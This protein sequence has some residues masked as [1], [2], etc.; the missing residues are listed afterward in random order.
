M[1]IL[2]RY[3]A[4]GRKEHVTWLKYGL[5][6]TYSRAILSFDQT[7]IICLDRYIFHLESVAGPDA[8]LPKYI[9]S[10]RVHLRVQAD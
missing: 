4:K 6:S 10:R 8:A 7:F 3:S 2:F 1:E 5:L 9:P